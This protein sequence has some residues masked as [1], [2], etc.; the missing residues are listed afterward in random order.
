MPKFELEAGV[1][2]AHCKQRNVTVCTIQE[3]FAAC[4]PKKSKTK[5]LLEEAPEQGAIEA[6][7]VL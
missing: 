4:K 3:A 1:F 7:S 6:V 5:S 2:V